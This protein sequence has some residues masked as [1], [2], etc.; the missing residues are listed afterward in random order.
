MNMPAP[1]GPLHGITRRE[2]LLAL[3]GTALTLTG[4]G[5]GGD[6]V[7]AGG[8]AGVSSGGTGFSVGP[9]TGIGSIIVNG[10]RFDDSGAQVSDDDGGAL[11][12]SGLKLGMLARVRS[13]NVSGTTG[14]ATSVEVGGE[15]QGR[16]SGTPNNSA[17]TF[18]VLGQTVK[19]TGSTIFDASLPSG[20][21]SLAADTIVEVH[22]VVDPAG[23]TIQATFIER[24]TSPKEFKLQGLIS[25]LDTAKKQFSIGSINVDYSGAQLDSKVTLTEK[26]LVRV[27]LNAVLPPTSAPATWTAS[28]VRPPEDAQL[29]DRDEAEV[30]GIIN[31]FIS[32]ASFSVNGLPVNAA[33]ATFPKGTGGVALGSLVEVKGRLSGGVLFAT[34]V[35]PEDESE[36]D[37]LEFELHGT[38]SGLTST[39]FT[40]TSSGGIAVS[41]TFSTGTTF[42][43]GTAAGLANGRRVEVRG[44]A[45]GSSTRSTSIAATRI[46]FES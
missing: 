4:C 10:I 18:V 9:I 1:S 8:F 40:V 21:G 25:K 38:V 15:L 29:E 43:N 27:R 46:H 35:K 32:T 39:S 37:A 44:A 28:R 6:T 22:G 24:K 2:S 30:K 5:G 17:R 45:A 11:S 7:G 14:T 34:R 19:V 42:D 3:C 36:I 33:G 41:V 26:T 12:R 20:F 16:I 23:N 13:T 31:A